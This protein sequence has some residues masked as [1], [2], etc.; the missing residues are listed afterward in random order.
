M[1]SLC[2][3]IELAEYQCGPAFWLSKHP[4]QRSVLCFYG[5]GYGKT[6]TAVPMIIKLY[7]M[8]LIDRV[9]TISQNQYYKT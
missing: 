5:T 2:P 7:G 8:K 3:D 9:I 6:L 4:E 1:S